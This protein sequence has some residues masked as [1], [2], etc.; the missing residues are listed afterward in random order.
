M[1]YGSYRSRVLLFSVL[2]VIN[3]SLSATLLSVN[4]CCPWEEE[5]VIIYFILVVPF[6]SSY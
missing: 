1:S 2:F 4:L 5:I 6:G 3:L